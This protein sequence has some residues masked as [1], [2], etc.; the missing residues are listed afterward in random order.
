MAFDPKQAGAAVNENVNA[1]MQGFAAASKAMQAVTNEMVSMS[2]DSL[3]QTAHAFEQMQ[4]ARNWTDVMRIQS[5]FF[6]NS[7]EE[8]AKRSR[9]IAE[10]A[11]AAPVDLASRT[12]DAAARIGAQTQ[13]AAET[14]AD[15]A[16]AATVGLDTGVPGSPAS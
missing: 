14:V 1:S 3:R 5:E 6:R 16:K 15:D 11:S 12:R 13:A 9:R 8:F 7:F 2:M 10:L 4:G